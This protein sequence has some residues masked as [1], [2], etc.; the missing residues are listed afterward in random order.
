[1]SGR[2]RRGRVRTSRV[3]SLRS[4]RPGARRSTARI[5]STRERWVRRACLERG[6]QLVGRQRQR[7]EREAGAPQAQRGQRGGRQP[8]AHRVQFLGAVAQHRVHRAVGDET[9]VLVEH[10]D[11][12]DEADRGVEVVLDEQDRAVAVRHELGER[13]VD[14]LDPLRVEVRGRLVEH[15]QRRAHRERARD[16]QPLPSAAG[17]AVGVLGAALPQADAAQRGL[18]AREH[19]GHRHPEVLRPERDFV[20]QRAGDQ[21]RVGVLEDHADMRAQ[22]GDRWSRDVARRRPRSCR[23]P[24]RAPR[25]G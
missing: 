17:Q 19:L 13:G 14:L 15:E 5:A 18:G 24:R 22:L 3:A 21:L 10:D 4:L 20:E 6:A 9:A 8:H 1:M 2:R 11:A 25:A 23:A 16:R 12:V 7:V